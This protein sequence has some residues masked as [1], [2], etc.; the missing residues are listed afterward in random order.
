MQVGKSRCEGLRPAII[1]MVAYRLCG[2]HAQLGVGGIWDMTHFW[3]GGRNNRMNLSVSNGV[4]EEAN[5]RRESLF[6]TRKSLAS[7]EGFPREIFHWSAWSGFA[8]T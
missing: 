4:G 2:E 7:A 6:S 1:W 3:G 8:V 5:L